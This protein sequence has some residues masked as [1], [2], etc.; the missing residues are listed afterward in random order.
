MTIAAAATTGTATSAV[1]TNGSS[2]SH[3]KRYC[4][5]CKREI[6]VKGYENH[7]KTQLHRERAKGKKRSRPWLTAN[8]DKTYYDYKMNQFWCDICKKNVRLTHKEA[9]KRTNT[10][11]TCLIVPLYQRKNSRMST[12]PTQSVLTTQQM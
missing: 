10:K 11:A 2:Q 1:Q 3:D 9:H 7:Y 12:C 6:T 5:A 4:E 8:P